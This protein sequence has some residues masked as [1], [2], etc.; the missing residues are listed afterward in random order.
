MKPIILPNKYITIK[1]KIKRQNNG[2]TSDDKHNRKMFES[3]HRGCESNG[4]ILNKYMTS[5]RV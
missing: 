5:N 2:V 3:K 4:Y 1:G